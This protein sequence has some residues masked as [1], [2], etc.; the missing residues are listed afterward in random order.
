MTETTAAALEIVQVPVDLI[1][2]NPWNPNVQSETVKRAT[3]E[4]LTRYGFVEPVLL[5][6]HPND[7]GRFQIVNG[8]HRHAQ[9]AELG[10]S[11]IPAVVRDL[12]DDDAKKLTIILNETTGDADVVLLGQLLA[13][14]QLLDDFKIGLPYTDM[15]LEHLLQV[16][17]TDWSRFG[18]PPDPPAHDPLLEREVVLSFTDDQYDSFRGWIVILEKEYG[19]GGVSDLVFEAVRRAAISANQG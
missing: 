6:P 13:E 15:E 11:T 18:D 19:T 1:D 12:S 9:A 8:E 10:Y 16:A 5:R 4:S 14:L 2:R 17:D 7:P 3:G